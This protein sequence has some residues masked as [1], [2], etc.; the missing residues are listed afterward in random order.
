MHST[1]RRDPGDL[2]CG[3]GDGDGDGEAMEGTTILCSY[4]HASGRCIEYA[5]VGV[6]LMLVLELRLELELEL[7]LTA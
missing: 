7:E 5:P 6:D 4:I 3:E 1:P 2:V